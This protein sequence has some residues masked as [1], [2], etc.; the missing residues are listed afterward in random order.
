M[1]TGDTRGPRRRLRNSLD[2]AR[3]TFGL[4]V[5]R[6][7]PLALDGGRFE[8]LPDRMVALDEV[9]E[10]LL[11]RR[12]P[13]QTSD[14]VWAW[15]VERSRV[16]GGAWTVGAV[17]VALPALT[18]VTALLARQCP[19]NTADI[20][21]EVLCGF[22]EALSTVDI[23]RQRIVLRLRW[24][25]YRSGLRVV[26]KTLL[27]R[28]HETYR[29]DIAPEPAPGGHPDLVL[30]EA[31]VAGVVSVVEADVIGS[32]RLESV[33]IVQWAAERGMTQWAAYKCR[34]RA[35]MRLAGYLRDR[36]ADTAL[37]NKVPRTVAGH[38]PTQSTVSRGESRR[39]VSNEVGGS[40]LLGDKESSHGTASPEE[41][42]CA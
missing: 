21:A 41:R 30:A 40:G 28:A 8:G 19:G 32:T 38:V 33:P 2:I 31:V 20:A 15:L 1:H 26:T 37:A 39:V 14:A 13:Q 29:P 9:R 36:L 11:S 12:C 23:E 22:M 18:S 6:P 24:S 5:A 17:G 42:S 25:A 35:E 34:R 3:D 4:L 27:E 16:N 7:E 10:L